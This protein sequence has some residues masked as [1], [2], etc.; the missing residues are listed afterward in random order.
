MRLVL[1]QHTVFYSRL[2]AC[3]LALFFAT[4]QASTAQKPTKL[5]G[6]AN[7]AAEKGDWAGAYS[8]LQAAYAIDSTSFEVRDALALAAFEI[9]DFETAVKLFQVNYDKDKGQLRPDALFYLAAAQKR[10]GEYEN[11]QRNFKTYLKKYK[12]KGQKYFVERAEHEMKS[13]QWALQYASNDTTY[14]VSKGWEAIRTAQSEYLAAWSGKD[15]FF[16]RTDSSGHWRIWSHRDDESKEIEVATLD[17]NS[18]WANL[19][20]MDSVHVLF[21]VR[22]NDV[23]RIYS[24]KWNGVRITDANPVAALNTEGTQNTMPFVG[25]YNGEQ[26]VYFVSNRSNGEGGMDIWYSISKE[27]RWQKPLNAGVAVNSPGDELLPTYFFDQLFF[28]SD[29]RFGFGGMDVFVAPSVNGIWQSA[30]NLGDKVNSHHH[31]VAFHLDKDKKSFWLASSRSEELCLDDLTFGCLDVFQGDWNFK[32]ETKS[33]ETRR[34]YESLAA[35]NQALPVTLYFH[36]DEPNPKT[37]DT[38]STIDYAQS[39]E[40]YMALIPKYVDENTKS[41][42]SDLKEERTAMIQDFFEL[43]V[44]KGKQDLDAFC[45]LLLEELQSGHSVRIWIRGFASP[46]AKSEYNLNLT[47][48]RTSSLINQIAAMQNGVFMPYID[49]KATSGARLEFIQLPFGEMK[50]KQGVSDDLMDEEGSIYSRSASLERKIEI[51][52]ATI[53]PNTVKEPKL[54]KYEEV[55]DFGLISKYQPVKHVFYLPNEGNAPM[56]V[57]SV[58]AECG[59][60]TPEMDIKNILPGEKGQ[61]DV[62]FDPFGKKGHATKVVTVYIRGMEPKRITLEAEIEK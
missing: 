15:A 12:A 35:L 38:L 37:L 42:S 45:E 60:T 30:I 7:E 21:A 6:L 20:F 46:R 62:T 48:R 51:E 16:N 10:L 61:L 39:Y 5:R 11:A 54:G 22:A 2:A 29:Y 53:M 43:Q 41:I 44:K 34:F 8:Y 27:G 17:E 57:D 13:A 3:L 26:C 50:A 31:E 28:A 9:G 4:V 56:V 40:S 24:G 47:K 18:D 32:E 36:N 52:S 33:D 1:T 59:C 14:K 23:T 58:I 25:R 55:H 19:T 49:D